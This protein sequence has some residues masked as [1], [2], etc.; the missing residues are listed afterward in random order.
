MTSAV[1]RSQF[2]FADSWSMAEA[3]FPKVAAI[4]GPPRKPAV[5]VRRWVDYLRGISFGLPLVLSCVAMLVLHFSLWGGNLAIE[6]ATAVGAGAITSFILSGG[7]VQAMARRGLFYIGTRQYERCWRSTWYWVRACVLANVAVIAVFTLANLY[8]GWLPYPLALIAMSFCLTL[9]VFWLTTGILYMLEQNLLV[10][11]ASLAGI[12]GA[13]TLH[14]G[15]GMAL[16]SAQLI[17]ILLASCLSFLV[18]AFILK[19]KAAGRKLG[20]NGAPDNRLHLVWPYFCYGALYYLFLFFDRILAW[21]AHTNSSSLVIAFRGDYE[22]ASFIG[23]LAFI[24]QV[25][26]VHLATAR[27]YRTVRIEQ[28]RMHVDEIA[29]FNSTMLRF[30]RRQA[31]LFFPPA[32]LVSV[33]VYFGAWHFDLFRTVIVDNVA[34]WALAGYPFLVFGLWNVSLLFAMSRGS[35]ALQAIFMA[36]CADFAAGYLASR[37]GG[38]ELAIAGFTCGSIVFAFIAGHHC[39]E[40]FR[41]LDYFY[42]VSAV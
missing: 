28:A 8:F 19:R 22:L 23:L 12:S 13:A 5:P 27:F 37:L 36:C 42:L 17:S 35:C 6:A 20:G 21:T 3:W 41:R 11:L 1:A 7:F 40:T 34:V 9:G 25:G 24:L 33:A 2:G 15:L 10:S 30:Y 14:L 29:T 18:S 4:Q 39:L 26:W 16:L 32:V 31:A 38:Y